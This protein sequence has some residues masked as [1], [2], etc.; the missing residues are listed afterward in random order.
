MGKRPLRERFENRIQDFEGGPLDFTGHGNLLG[1]AGYLGVQ[2]IN[3]TVTVGTLG[4]FGGVDIG[5][6]A[7]S[8]GV[9]EDG[10]DEIHTFMIHA[11]TQ[12]IAQFAAKYLSA[13]SNFD[14]ASGD[15]EL[16]VVENVQDR[17]TA[18]TW[19]IV[20]RVHPGIEEEI[21]Q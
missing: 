12:D 5:F 21:V 1:G 20:V 9:E 7:I 4:T 8:H 18:P 10:E 13:P 14:F 11:W 15:T 19:R 17:R 3:S 16:E 6:R 2:A